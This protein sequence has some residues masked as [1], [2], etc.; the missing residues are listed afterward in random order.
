MMTTATEIVTAAL[1]L[2]PDSRIAII[3]QLLAS[4]RLADTVE[5]ER[6]WAIEVEDR[7]LAYECGEMATIPGEDVFGELLGLNVLE[8]AA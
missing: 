6:L 3:R 7:I 1:S 4:L 8:I 2:S 5:I